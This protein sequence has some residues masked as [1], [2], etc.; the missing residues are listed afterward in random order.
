MNDEPSNRPEVKF[1]GVP[2]SKILSNVEKDINNSG[3]PSITHVEGLGIATLLSGAV[4]MKKDRGEGIR[5][6]SEM[7]IVFMK[8]AAR[9]L[10]GMTIRENKS[11]EEVEEMFVAAA[12]S[13]FAKQYDSFKKFS[14][15]ARAGKNPDITISNGDEG[16]FAASIEA[17]EK[18]RES[19]KTSGK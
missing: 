6:S 15:E 19:A 7:M 2:L 17:I 11:R 9:H 10:I 12:K 1:R 4:K 8:H 5:Y 3:D 16:A 18:A 14:A 13:A